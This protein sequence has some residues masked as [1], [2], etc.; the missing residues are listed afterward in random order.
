[1]SHNHVSLIELEVE[2]IYSRWEIPLEGV[3]LDG[4][5]LPDSAVPGQGVN[6]TSVSALIDTVSFVE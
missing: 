2:S 5:K 3:Y 6:S 1:M 4:Q